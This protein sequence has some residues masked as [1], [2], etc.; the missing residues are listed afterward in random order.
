MGLFGR[1]KQKSVEEKFA[2]HGMTGFQTTEN[3]SRKTVL[4]DIKEGRASTSRKD[5]ILNRLNDLR[6][7]MLYTANYDSQSEAI[8]EIISKL[9]SSSEG[10]N[11]KVKNIIDHL[12][13][14]EV[15]NC[16]NYFN[17]NNTAAVFVSLNNLAELVDERLSCEAYFENEEF[18]DALLLKNEALLSLENVR[19]RKE[20]LKKEH[21]EWVTLYNDPNYL[22]DKS[23]LY[24][25]VQQ[26]KKDRELLD[27]EIAKL[28]TNIEAYQNVLS[29]FRSHATNNNDRTLELREDL[30]EKGLETAQENEHIYTSTNKSLE[31]FDSI[32]TSSSV[33]NTK[34]NQD[35]VNG[36]GSAKQDLPETLSFDD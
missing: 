5:E 4:Q 8:E 6:K 11:P 14:N 21:R 15:L 9:K 12:L 33:K 22:G 24:S 32:R 36:T 1:K 13:V 23:V 28:E 30:I 20:R 29:T 26:N 10:R 31:K 3:R 18:L 17:R 7:K 27:N 2:G 16:E 35:L 25:R 19:S 34:V